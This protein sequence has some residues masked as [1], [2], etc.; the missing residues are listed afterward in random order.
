MFLLDPVRP[1]PVRAHF[2]ARSLR[3]AR[4]STTIHL[5]DLLTV[6]HQGTLTSLFTRKVSPTHPTLRSEFVVDRSPF[7]LAHFNFYSKKMGGVSP[8]TI[9]VYSTLG[10]SQHGT[11]P[12]SLGH[13]LRDFCVCPSDSELW[14][15]SATQR[16]VRCQ[17]PTGGFEGRRSTFFEVIVRWYLIDP[18]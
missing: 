17:P 7:V 6:P 3:R 14:P 8:R 18:R 11:S 16:E 12:D 15:S 5:P 10:T 13:W 9:R 4:R 1:L 2:T